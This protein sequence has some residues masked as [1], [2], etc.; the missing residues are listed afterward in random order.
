[1]LFATQ[2]NVAAFAQD[3]QGHTRKRHKTYCNFPHTI[4][5][6]KKALRGE[7]QKIAPTLAGRDDQLTYK[8]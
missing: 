7:P 2:I 6:K 4:S 5:F 1:M 3:E 8:T